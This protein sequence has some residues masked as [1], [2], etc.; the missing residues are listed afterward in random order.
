MN[1]KIT[2]TTFDPIFHETPLRCV[3]CSEN[4]PVFR[5]EFFNGVE[6]LEPEIGF[7]CVSCAPEILSKL[8][9]AEC[10]AWREEEAALK[11]DDVDISELHRWRVEAFHR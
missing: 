10:Q 5:Y 4:P 6:E 11:A 9:G 3:T 2:F 8:A 7:C 1:G